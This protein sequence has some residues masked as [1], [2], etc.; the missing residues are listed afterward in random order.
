MKSSNAAV[1]EM[2]KATHI[3]FSTRTY[4][5]IKFYTVYLHRG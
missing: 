1:V 5:R 3:G 2:N 4:H